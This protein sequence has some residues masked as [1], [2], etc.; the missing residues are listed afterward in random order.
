MT[1][2]KKVV[3]EIKPRTYALCTIHAHA[4]LNASK[5][6]FKFG[7]NVHHSHI[8]Y[9]TT[10]KTLKELASGMFGILKGQFKLRFG[11][12]DLSSDFDNLNVFN[13]N[14]VPDSTLF[15]EYQIMNE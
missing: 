12:T 4:G 5:V 14:I 11:D 7:N 2:N 3:D 15:V 10:I 13:L 9:S 1:K 8:K 6:Q